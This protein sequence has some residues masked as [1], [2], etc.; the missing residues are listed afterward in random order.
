MI[1]A[2]TTLILGGE[3]SVAGVSTESGDTLWTLP[4]TGRV[5]GLAFARG[6]L[7]ASS[8]LGTVHCYTAP[9]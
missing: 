5:H 2:G 1:Q 9:Q 3:D 4:A 8:D 6:R 7:F